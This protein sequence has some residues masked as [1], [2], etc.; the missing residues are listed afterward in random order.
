MAEIASTDKLL[1]G[2]TRCSVRIRRSRTVLALHCHLSLTPTSQFQSGWLQKGQ[3]TFTPTFDPNPKYRLVVDQYNTLSRST[4]PLHDGSAAHKALDLRDEQ[5]RRLVA[6]PIP[7]TRWTQGTNEGGRL[8]GLNFSVKCE[9]VVCP[10]FSP[11]KKYF[12]VPVVWYEWFE[13]TLYTYTVQCV[14]AF[15][16]PKWFAGKSPAE[17]TY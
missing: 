16:I 7:P 15:A 1:S 12:T 17:L 14:S 6:I 2:D 4:V 3:W 9:W 13:C 5:G 11:L 10:L 8:Q